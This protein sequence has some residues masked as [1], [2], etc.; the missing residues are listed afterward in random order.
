MKFKLISKRKEKEFLFNGKEYS[1]R[2]FLVG[3]TVSRTRGSVHDLPSPPSTWRGEV[4]D[5]LTIHGS[6]LVGPGGQC[7]DAHG[8]GAQ[9]G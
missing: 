5:R 1:G 4:V 2:I 9:N 8:P 6:V 7:P 3:P